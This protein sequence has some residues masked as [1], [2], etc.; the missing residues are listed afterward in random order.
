M[1]Y[2]TAANTA[3]RS[4]STAVPTSL[5]AEGAEKSVLSFIVQ[6]WSRL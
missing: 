2:K 6:A 4:L 1:T 5:S 3:S